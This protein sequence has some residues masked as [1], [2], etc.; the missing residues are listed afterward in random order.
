V[1]GIFGLTILIVAAMLFFLSF[2]LP[3]SAAGTVVRSQKALRL[4]LGNR[5]MRFL[6]DT[7]Y[8]VYLIHG[9]FISLVGG[10]LLFSASRFLKFPPS[11]RVGLLVLTTAAGSYL[12]AWFLHR[13]IERPGIAI[14][15]V[16]VRSIPT[17]AASARPARN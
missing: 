4:A 17:R 5:F 1:F 11:A 8:S 16:I 12:V 3:D 10:N 15:R 9:L 13:V 14:G 2:N 6:A 7:S